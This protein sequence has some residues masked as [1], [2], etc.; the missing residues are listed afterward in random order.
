VCGYLLVLVPGNWLLFRLLGKV[1]WAWVAAPLIALACTVLVIRWAEL[2]IGFA[3]SVTELAVVEMQGD[4]QR[5]H[6]T[7]Y[8]ALYTSWSTRYAFESDD[9]GLEILPFPSVEDPATFH[10]LPGQGVTHLRYDYGER[11]S[12]SGFQVWSNTTDC[13]HS[14]QMLDLGGGFVLEQK[15]GEPIHVLNQSNLPL[16]GAG[17]LRRNE[18][19]HLEAAWIGSLDPGKSAELDFVDWNARD[20]ESEWSRH[21][22]ESPV[23][24]RLAP[25]GALNVRPLWDLAADA[26]SLRPGDVR[27]VGWVDRRL[28]GLEIRPA[29]PQTRSVA[30]VVARLHY[31]FGDDPRP[32]KNTRAEFDKESPRTVGPPED[33]PQPGS[34]F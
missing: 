15:P 5:A 14:E 33:L 27:L 3:R 29:A 8:T 2:D 10:F 31:A 1:E 28:S 32:D 7:R 18:Q 25:P 16:Q 17:V 23:T 13:V 21:L 12:L 11:V 20:R 6:V 24:S 34:A 30:L 19:Q 9:P 22:E 26:A 4:Y